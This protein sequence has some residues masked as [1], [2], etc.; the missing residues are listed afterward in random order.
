MLEVT[1]FKPNKVFGE[2]SLKH[3]LILG[4]LKPDLLKK[5]KIQKAE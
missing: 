3:V 1:E 5:V 4:E 2:I